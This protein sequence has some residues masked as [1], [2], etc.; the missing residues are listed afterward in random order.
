MATALIIF[1]CV[2]FVVSGIWSLRPSPEQR[3]IAELRQDA[4][5]LGM[6]IRLP[7]AMKVSDVIKQL[8]KPLYRKV[9]LEQEKKQR[10]RI[11]A[12]AYA[13]IN[14]SDNAHDSDTLNTGVPDECITLV[15]A[16]PLNILAIYIGEGR[17]GVI[18]DENGSREDLQILSLLIDSM[19]TRILRA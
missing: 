19:V 3:R 6:E 18:W 11:F 7:L 13:L 4:I 15:E 9:I 1:L 2:M 12:D 17:I 5:L 16:C 14:T 8:K 10:E